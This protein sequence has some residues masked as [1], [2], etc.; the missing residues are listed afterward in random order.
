MKIICIGDSLTHGYPF[1]EKYSWTDIVSGLNGWEMV[2][3]G[4]NGESSGEILKRIRRCGYFQNGGL[5]EGSET[6]ADKVTIM[7]GSNDFVYD[8]GGV[9]DV[10]ANI[11]QMVLMAKDEGI[12]PVVMIPPLC[13]PEQAREAWMDGCGIDYEKVNRQLRTLA[14]ELMM[15]KGKFDFDLID[16]QT[17]YEEYHKYVDGLHPTKDGYELIAQ[18]VKEEL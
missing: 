18:I 6:K 8:L 2:N 11:L 7:C 9:S 13:E 17:K 3:R 12:R 4:V 15:A 14:K 1:G 16:I 5:A 10:L